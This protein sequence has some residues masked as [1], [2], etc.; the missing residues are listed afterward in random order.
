[1][2]SERRIDAVFEGGGVKGSALVGALAATEAAGYTYEN[3]AGTSAGAIV[4][5]LV[6]AGYSAGEMKN[7]IDTLDYRRFQDR[8]V[9]NRI[10]F[11]GRP[12]CTLFNQGWYKGKEFERWM[13]VLL[14]AKNIRTYKDLIVSE[15]AADPRYRYKLQVVASDISRGKLLI[16]PRDAA[17]YGIN[18]DDLDVVTSIRMSMS[19]P[20]FYS[21]VVQRGSNGKS[22][23]VDGGILSNF[24]VFLFDDN[25]ENPPWPTIGYKLVD[26]DEN[27]PHPVWGPISFSWA[28]IQTMMEAHDARYIADRDFIRTVPIPTL[29]V[30]TT[31]FD[32][33][34]ARKQALYQSGLTAG[35]EFFAKWNFAEYKEKYRQAEPEHRT[36]RVWD[37]DT[38]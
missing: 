37:T 14:E 10:P 21:P 4:A 24:P 2:N 12:V 11:I 7:I 19:I 15:Y 33:S 38:K 18:P 13:R 1:M 23:I 31:E 17:D 26:P 30:Q 35:Q 20:Y 9:L 22:Y 36:D 29:G 32:I 27:K 34:A 6:A 8:T 28:L 3:V 25:T 16:L 5:A